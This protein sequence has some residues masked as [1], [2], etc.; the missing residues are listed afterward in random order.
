VGSIAPPL[1]ALALL[2]ASLPVGAEETT[3]TTLES[4]PPPEQ[5]T[6]VRGTMPEGIVGRWLVVGWVELPNGKVSAS[7]P[8]LWEI[9]RDGGQPVLTVRFAQLPPDLQKKVN[10]KTN[11]GQRWEPSPEEVAQVAAAWDTLAPIDP[12]LHT[13][14]NEIVARD[15]FDDAFKS[16]SMSKDAIWAVRQV[17]LFDPSAAPTIKEI[18]V[19]SVLEPRGAG[20]YGNYVAA[21]I[22]AAPLPVPITLRGHFQL[23]RLSGEA[24]PPGL[25]ARLL[26]L[27]SGCGR[28]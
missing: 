9:T 26:D 25:L 1:L 12:R 14:E 5:H 18:N 8:A 6:T 22:A 27:F 7:V 20:F 19:Y 3:R 16:D 4:L 23:Y 28:R 2:L 13:V 11:T 10:D 17:E 21:T 24:P 15:G